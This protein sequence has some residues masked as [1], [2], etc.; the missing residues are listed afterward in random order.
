MA[1]AAKKIEAPSPAQV[2]REAVSALQ[3]ERTKF[4]ELGEQSNRLQQFQRDEDEALAAMNAL[5][6]A[7]AQK[8]SEWASSGSS[9]QAPTVDEVARK[10]ASERLAN[11]QRQWQA[12]QTAKQDIDARY[13]AQAQVIVEAELAVKVAAADIHGA[14]LVQKFER[15]REA[16][17]TANEAEVDYE[18][19]KTRLFDL[20]HP[21]TSALAESVGA[22][23]R[24]PWFSAEEELG[25]KARA[26][27]RE[28]QRWEE[29]L[30]G[31]V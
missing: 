5:A 24:L 10:R 4:A 21:A 20:Q 9:G 11:A 28:A 17:I 18:G 26:M 1:F 13:M 8:F 7:E 25:W 22:R 31:K 15:L 12:A 29:L 3:A 2:L 6:A 14:D 23:Q 30:Q 27:Q 19:T 16:V